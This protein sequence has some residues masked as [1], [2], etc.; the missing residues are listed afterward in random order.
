MKITYVAVVLLLMSGTE[1]TLNAQGAFQNL[2]FEAAHLTVIPPGQPGVFI[3]FASG[4]PGWSGFFGIQPA[5]QVFQNGLTTGAAS[6][7]ILVPNWTA[8]E[9]PVIQGRNSVVLQ[10]GDIVAGQV[11]ATIAQTGLVPAGTK[12]IEAEFSLSA[13]DFTVFLNGENITMIPLATTSTFTLFGGDVPDSI[14][15]QTAELSISALPA[16]PLNAFNLFAVDAISF[17]PE[18]TPEPATWTL[19]FVSGA[20]AVAF[21]HWNQR[22]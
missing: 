2:N 6:I 9:F 1:P 7:D 17:S 16:P 12:S 10:A 18:S 4:L 14:A 8:P 20:A 5:T 22:G 11:A 19:M 15:G 13:G 3:P 21:R